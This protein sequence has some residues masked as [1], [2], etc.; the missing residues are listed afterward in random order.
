[1][2]VCSSNGAVNSNPDPLQ[3][4]RQPKWRAGEV[5]VKFR[6][7]SDPQISEPVAGSKLPWDRLPRILRQFN[8]T[9]S[10]ASIKPVAHPELLRLK[11]AG[12]LQGTYVLR[13]SDE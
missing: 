3:P 12:A 6:E 11:Q 1:M 7:P 2:L 4:G 8:A 5:I 10:I 13:F 9:N